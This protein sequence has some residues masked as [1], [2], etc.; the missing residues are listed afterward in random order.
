MTSTKKSFVKGAAILGITSFLVKLIGVL[1]RIP[2][3]NIL[4]AEGAGLYMKAYPIYTF[5]LTLSTAGLPPTIAKLVAEKVSANDYSGA[6][7]VFKVSLVLMT[8]LGLVL[9]ISLLLLSKKL[10]YDVYKNPLTWY[11]VATIAPAIALVSIMAAI[12]GYFQGLQNMIPTAVSQLAEQVGKIIFGITLAMLLIPKGIEYGAA[13][14][15]GGVLISEIIGLLVVIAFYIKKAPKI[16]EKTKTD[17]SSKE[18]LK[19][20]LSIAFPILLGASIMPLIQFIDSLIITARLEFLSYTQSASTELFGLFSSY[21]NTLVNV[22]GS[23]SLAFCVSMVPAAAAAVATKDNNLLKRNIK[24]GYKLSL[25]VAIP[26]AVGLY[27][28]AHPIMNLLYGSKLSAEYLNIS[29]NL[30]QIIS[31]GIIFL[32]ILQTFNGLLQGMGKVYIPVIALS[33]GAITKIILCY[34]LVGTPYFNIYGAPISTFACYAVAATIDIVVIKKLTKAKFS[35]NGFNIKIVLASA[36]MG[37]V[38]W[39]SYEIIKNIMGAKYATLISVFIGVIVFILG[40]VIFKILSKEEIRTIPGG[41]KLAKIYSAI[42]ER[43]NEQ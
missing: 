31:G 5:L 8:T 40:L 26:S 39:G 17:V 9:S 33:A 41:S 29:A 24:L 43:N 21:V 14:A 30:L 42:W 1:Y 35:D 13:G 20:I 34:I 4:G 36:L 37:A 12:R 2:L 38:V 7:K 11:P 23:I 22:P 10:A 18:V 28:L 16:K 32:S 19:Q 15:V 25:M 27:I 6:K 3:N